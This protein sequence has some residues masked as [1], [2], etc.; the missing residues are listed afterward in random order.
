MES[1]PILVVAIILAVIIYL[2]NRG[3]IMKDMKKAFMVSA[4]FS[5]GGV[6]FVVVTQLIEGSGWPLNTTLLILYFS[7]MGLLSIY[8]YRNALEN[9]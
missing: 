2:L 7:A 9:N 8:R 6:I 3:R 5:V 1:T 4:L